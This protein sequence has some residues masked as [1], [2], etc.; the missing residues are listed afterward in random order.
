MLP[1]LYFYARVN[2]LTTLESTSDAW[3]CW[4]EREI[5]WLYSF[6]MSQGF[7]RLITLLKDT[8]ISIADF[9]AFPFVVKEDYI[10]K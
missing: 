5:S 7:K 1:V 10:L 9:S 6:V 3:Q 2:F 4:I 8:R